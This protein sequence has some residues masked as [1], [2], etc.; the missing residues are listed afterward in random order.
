MCIAIGG[1]T[2]PTALD[3]AQV[4]M[5][6]QLYSEVRTL[7]KHN[8][9]TLSAMCAEL[10]QHALKTPTYKQQMDEALIVVPPKEDPRMA[11]PQTQFRGDAVKAAIEGADLNDAK[12]KKLMAILEMLE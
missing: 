9:R 5:Q 1:R 3:R 10:I 12:L 8:R 4:L 2:I 11:S 6:P 7:A